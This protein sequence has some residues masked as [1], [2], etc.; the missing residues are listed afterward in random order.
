M[1][2]PP[3]PG[4]YM[5]ARPEFSA[6]DLRKC[7]SVLRIVLD[8]VKKPVFEAQEWRIARGFATVGAAN[9]EIAIAVKLGLVE[10]I[11][12][13]FSGGFGSAKPRAAVYKAVRY[14]A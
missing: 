14:E 6:D 9:R 13:A 1:V 8:H 11:A 3:D 4:R 7:R 5:P 12:P 2:S 10:C